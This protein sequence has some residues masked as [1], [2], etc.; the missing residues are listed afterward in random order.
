MFHELVSASRGKIHGW[1]KTGTTIANKY[2]MDA[3]K[4][5]LFVPALSKKSCLFA[6]NVVKN[7]R[8]RKPFFPNADKADIIIC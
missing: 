1:Q 5:C 7:G 6:K 8:S 2:S 3:I 4:K